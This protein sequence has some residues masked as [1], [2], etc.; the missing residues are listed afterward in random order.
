MKSP[1]PF[2]V[3]AGGGSAVIGGI[4][5]ISGGTGHGLIVEMGSREVCAIVDGAPVAV[6]L[7]G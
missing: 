6:S 2:I 7:R 4:L 1:I 5:F 3:A